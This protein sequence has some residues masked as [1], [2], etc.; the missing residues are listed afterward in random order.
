[1]FEI[2]ALN[3]ISHVGLKRLPPELYTVSKEAQS[4][5]AILVRSHDMH[6]M[7]IADSVLAIGR[8]GAGTNNIPVKAMSERGVPVFNAPGANANAVKELVLAGMLIGARNLAP[9]LSF[10]SG[11]RGGVGGSGGAGG[12]SDDEAALAKRIE[13]GKKQF[14]GIERDLKAGTAAKQAGPRGDGGTGGGSGGGKGP[15]KGRGNGPGD[16]TGVPGLATRAEVLA[17]RW[18]FNPSGS[19]REHVEKLTAAG[20]RVGFKDGNDQFWLIR[21][22]K[23]RPVDFQLESFDK[24]NDTVKWFSQ[25]PRSVL[26]MAHELRLPGPPQFFVLLLP[27]DREQK[28][29][30]AEFQFAKAR[31]RDLKRVEET[32]FDFRP[33]GGAFEPVV[34]G[35]VP[36]EPRPKW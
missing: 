10:V 9:A 18:R 20:V 4:P 3:Q 6:E 12:T 27:K 15:G 35:Q 2:L 23:K 30:D 17:Q 7:S 5:D 24:Y 31:N 33:V 1:M 26:G 13:D 28:L 14:A 29:A 36:F 25:E 21:D 32:W 11:L 8:A 16:G 22:L 19:P 34:V